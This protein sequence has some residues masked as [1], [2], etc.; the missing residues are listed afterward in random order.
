MEFEQPEEALRAISMLSNSVRLACYCCCF[1]HVG[2]V[3]TCPDQL[4]CRKAA[5]SSC[6]KLGAGR[7][8]RQSPE[9]LQ[10]L[11]GRAITVREDREDWSVKGSGGQD[12]GGRGRG[13]APRTPVGNGEG[14]ATTSDKSGRQ[15][16]LG[17]CSL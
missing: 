2:C 14:A 11:D 17:S 10:M 6:T 15:V 13:S 9:P 5:S 3:C 16:C 12:R 4:S 7:E 1:L 8:P